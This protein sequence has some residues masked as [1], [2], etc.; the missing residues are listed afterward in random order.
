MPPIPP[1]RENVRSIVPGW[2]ISAR[3]AI[4][5]SA[6]GSSEVAR[7]AAGTW[8]PSSASTVRRCSGVRAANASA[9]ACSIA[10]G[11]AVRSRYR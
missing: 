6:C 5:A 2:R 11:G 8:L 7:S 4:R 10:S 1:D 9:W 3:V